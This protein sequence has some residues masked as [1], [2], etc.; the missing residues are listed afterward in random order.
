M[1][2]YLLRKDGSFSDAADY[3]EKPAERNDG[4]WVEGEP[5]ADIKPHAPDKAPADAASLFMA[6][7]VAEQMKP[8][9]LMPFLLAEFYH[10]Q[11]KP[12]KLKEIAEAA[13]PSPEALPIKEQIKEKLD[14]G[15]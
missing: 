10:R 12:E 9:N 13:Q 5:L 7:P 14:G 3:P 15:S 1:K 8:E 4:A 6:M 11:G 2:L